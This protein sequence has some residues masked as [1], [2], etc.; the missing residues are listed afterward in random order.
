VDSLASF[1]ETGR[2]VANFEMETSAMYGLA[3]LLG[4]KTLSI[5]AV[6]ANRSTGTFASDPG[7]AVDVM[8]RR[9]LEV[10]VNKML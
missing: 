8:I 5:S 2:K 10:I 6:V 4:H 7:H 3:R 9:S 1:R